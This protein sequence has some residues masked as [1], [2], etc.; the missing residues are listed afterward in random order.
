MFRVRD[1]EA[2]RSVGRLREARA[3]G[4][5]VSI[6]LNELKSYNCFELTNCSAEVINRK[7][8]DAQVDVTGPVKGF[9][10]RYCEIVPFYSWYMCSVLDRSQRAI[11]G[12]F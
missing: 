10:L 7:V 12:S 8:V 11:E 6:L 4:A 9:T 5:R 3:C 1:V 2:A